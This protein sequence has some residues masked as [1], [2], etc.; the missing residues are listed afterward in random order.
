M[1]HKTSIIDS[2]ALIGNNV[3]IGPYSMVGP[4]VEIG[5]D[6]IIQTDPSSNLSGFNCDNGEEPK[7]ITFQR[8]YHR[9]ADGSMSYYDRM[10]GT[11]TYHP[12]HGH[13]HSDDWG[14]FT[15]R[16]MD[17]NEPNPLNWP[18]VSD[19]AKM[20]FCLMDYGTCG[21]STSS[22]YYGHCRDENRYSP[23][24]LE[25]FPE[26]DDDSNGG[27]VK[28]NS[29]FPNFGLG[30]GNYGWDVNPITTLVK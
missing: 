28:Y 1:I 30:G 26:Y 19:G 5:D 15:L 9:N 10:A 24:Y 3:K 21:T 16:T 13:N 27:N 12:T 22:T 25:Y 23:D 11:M 8:I 29:D 20:G 2:K 17:P 6:T 4:N 7:Q 14:V 18:I